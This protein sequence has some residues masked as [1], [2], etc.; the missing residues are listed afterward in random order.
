MNCGGVAISRSLLFLS[1][2]RNDEL[3]G[4]RACILVTH[5][6][7]TWAR[8]ALRNSHLLSWLNSFYRS[9]GDSP[10]PEEQIQGK[11][12]HQ[13]LCLSLICAAFLRS[14]FVLHI[15]ARSYFKCEGS[16]GPHVSLWSVPRLNNNVKCTLNLHDSVIW[17][18]KLNNLFYIVHMFK[19]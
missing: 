19:W 17:R 10:T 13:I 9:V 2:Q 18:I 5:L 14:C 1:Y 3:W 12:F 7:W 15:S 8:T 4:V 16:H 6:S 11:T